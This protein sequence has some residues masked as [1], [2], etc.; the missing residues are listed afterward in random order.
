MWSGL[1]THNSFILCYFQLPDLNYS[2]AYSHTCVV[3]RFI[4]AAVVVFKPSLVL[5]MELQVPSEYKK[6]AHF[7]RKVMHHFKEVWHLHLDSAQFL[8][9]KCSVWVFANFQFLHSDSDS[10]IS[11]FSIQ[12]SFILLIYRFNPISTLNV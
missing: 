7:N 2:L 12:L 4:P 1:V 11:A 6:N 5:F 10:V 3:N 9:L 8:K